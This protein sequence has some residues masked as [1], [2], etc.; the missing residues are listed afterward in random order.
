MQEVQSNKVNWD[1]IS[2]AWQL[3]STNAVTWIVMMLIVFVVSFIGY[4]PM[5]VAGVMVTAMAPRVDYNDPSTFQNIG[6]SATGSVFIFA[7]AGLITAVIMVVVMTFLMAGL[8]KAALKQSR[9]EQI[10]VGD[11]FSGKDRFIPLLGYSILFS[12]GVFI[13]YA[14][15]FVIPPL[16]LLVWPIMIVAMGFLFF[17]APQIIDGK[18]GVMDAIK[19]SIEITKA[20]PVMYILLSLVV[21]VISCIGAVAFGIG[22]LVTMPFAILIPAVAYRSVFGLEGSGMPSPPPP[23]DQW[24]N[25]P[26]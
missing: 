15:S 10:T 13:L 22:A 2:Q 19:N 3:F 6:A 23:P 17:A 25:N 21:G 1:W 5:I 9:G 14:I 8:F 26:R 20:D 4:I 24:M 12:C 16:F 11:I 18:A 7:I